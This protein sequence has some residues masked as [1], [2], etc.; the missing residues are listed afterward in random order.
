MSLGKRT[1]KLMDLNLVIKLLEETDKVKIIK[2][3]KQ[4]NAIHSVQ[5]L[6]DLAQIFKILNLCA[7][8]IEN[9]PCFIESAYN[10][11]KLCGLPFLKKK[12]SDEITYAEDTANSIALLGDLMK[13]P[14]SELR[15]QIC[16]C[17]VDFYHAEPPKKHITGYQ[18]ASSSYKIQMAEVG[19]LA[20]RM[21][22]SLALLENQLVEKLWVLKV[23]QHLSTSEVNCTLM[24]KAQAASGICAHLNDPDPSGQL[25]FRSSE[26][27]WNLLEKTSKEEI[28]Q[29]LSNLE[30]LLALKEEC[31]FTRDLILFATFSEVKSQNPLVKG[32]KLSNSYED[33]ELKKLLFNIIVILSKDFPTVQ[34]LIEGKVVLALFT[35]VKKPEKHKMIEWSA[36]QYEELQLHAIATLSSVAPLLIEEYMSYQGNARVLAFLEWCE[37]EDSFFSHGNSFH[38]T[39]GRGNKFAQMRYSLRLLRAM[40][41][42][43]D[44]TI[45]KDLCEKGTIQQLIGIFTNT[46]SKSNDKEEAIVLEIQSDILLILSGLCEHDIPRKVCMPVNQ[47]FVQISQSPNTMNFFLEIFGTEGVDIILHVMKTDPKKLQSGLGYNVLLFSTLDSIWCCI[48]GC[49]PSEDYFL[50]KEGIFLLLDLLALNQKKFY[51][52]ILGIMVEFCD[53]P[54]TTAHVNAWRGKKDQTAASLL[55]KLWRKEEKELGVKR[56][57]HGKIIDTKKPLFTSFQEEQ[58]VMP[59]PANCPT[60]AVMDVTENIR[61]K[62]Y[63]V[64]GKLDF[65]NLP[66][67]SAEDFVTLCIIHRY[68]DFKIGEIWNEIYE[69]IKLEKFRPVSTDKKVLETI[70]AASE[71]IGKMVASLQ[72]EMIESQARQDVQNEQKCYAKIQATHKQRELANKSWENFLARTSNAKTLKKAKRLQEKAVESSRYPERPPNAIFHRTDIKGLNTTVPSGRVVTVESTPARLVGGPLADTDIALKK[73]PIR[74]GALQRVKAVKTV[75]EPKTSEELSSISL[76]ILLILFTEIVGVILFE[77]FSVFS[78]LNV[79]LTFCKIQSCKYQSINPNGIGRSSTILS[80]KVGLPFLF[81]EKDLLCPA[82]WWIPGFSQVSSQTSALLPGGSPGRRVPLCGVEYPSS[83]AEARVPARGPACAAL[84]RGR[85]RLLPGRDKRS[86]PRLGTTPGLCSSHSLPSRTHPWRKTKGGK[87]RSATRRE[88]SPGALIALLH[89]LRRPALRGCGALARRGRR[90]RLCCGREGLRSQPD[91]R[92]SAPCLEAE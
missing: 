62:I 56:D 14:S 51:N 30:C 78:L 42:L 1:F 32:L 35:F 17:I 28:I 48:L 83:A 22:Q 84:A 54:K 69:E 76:K 13:I 24:M 66:G 26:I 49:Y 71:N 16:K 92:S 58:K 33:F 77:V 29:Q 18:Q 50:E 79:K 5:P 10:I 89:G 91:S 11:L 64:L 21:V 39:G 72:S 61:A 2:L 41:Y 4:Y 27:L 86:Q 60:I 23:L 46:I 44:E 70:T 53:N 43:E 45:N 67:L 87:Q 15:I 82:V 25:L 12:A 88:R 20:K 37:S 73:L 80:F 6:R 90:R 38:G 19:G 8:K 68:L 74:G 57:K 81:T 34:L 47:T 9:Q 55:I 3:K 85:G 63:A 40:V 52:L 75:N 65:E 59:L 31:G 36:A 7:G